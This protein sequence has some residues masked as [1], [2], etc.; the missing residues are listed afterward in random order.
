MKFKR[1]TQNFEYHYVIALARGEEFISTMTAF[2]EKEGIK[3]ALFHG[4]GAVERVQIGY[5]DLGKKEYF[6]RNE[7]GVFEVASMTGN[8]ALVDGKPF[9]HA[10]AVLSRCDETCACIGAHIKEAYVAV[11]LE[12]VLTPLRLKTARTLNEPIGLKLLDL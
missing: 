11:T 1:T 6:F 8:V 2:C 4:I 9:V 3:N 5:Y 7:P 10:H 12:V